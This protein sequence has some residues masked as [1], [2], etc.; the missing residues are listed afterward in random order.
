MCNG[1]TADSDSAC[2]GSNPYSPA[3]RKPVLVTGF[4]FG[5]PQE[6]FSRPATES[7]ITSE[8]SNKVL[9]KGQVLIPQ[10]IRNNPNTILQTGNVFGFSFMLMRFYK[11]KR[12]GQPRD[13][14]LFLYN[15]VFNNINYFAYIHCVKIVC[16][17]PFRH[18]GAVGVT[19]IVKR[20]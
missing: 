13:C 17:V 9:P 19:D 6:G 2:W 20:D 1:S 7:H 12:C 18:N 16:R 11:Q 3:K 15:S 8:A 14:P 4:S 5:L 10:P